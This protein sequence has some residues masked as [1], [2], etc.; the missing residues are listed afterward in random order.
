MNDMQD[1]ARDGAVQTVADLIARA[2]A[3]ALAATLD[4]ATAPGPGD[5]LPPMWH[6]I[7]FWWVA[8]QSELGAD[9][10]PAK[11]GLL[12]DLGLPRRMAAGG[13][14]TFHA[15]LT[16]GASADRTSRVTS[17]EHKD[18]RSGRLAFATVEHRIETNGVL[19]IREEQ[20]IV[21][22]EPA[23]PG[24]PLPAPKATPGDAQ[25]LREILPTEALL[26][27][28][29]ALTFNGHRIHYDRH[30][31]QDVEGYPDL[32]VHGPLIA[33]LL[34]DLVS[35]NLPGAVVREYTYK[36]VRPTFVGH[37]FALCG[38][39]AADGKSV[40]LWAK[41]HEGWLTMSACAVL[42]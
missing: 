20:D 37:A 26:Y 19:A 10:H 7:Y 4:C 29:C 3:A 14:L 18:G 12:P 39:P 22:R 5:A 16:V 6:W 27:R 2:P 28:Y 15:P 8:P 17:V 42:A 40:E 34:L 25:W 32:V 24:T 38:R 41:D 23:V 13:R 30:Y 1:D 21:Y 31:A 36:A 33:T 9:G 11:G 35:R